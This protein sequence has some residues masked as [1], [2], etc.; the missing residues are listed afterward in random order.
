DVFPF[1]SRIADTCRRALVLDTN[2]SLSPREERAHDGFTYR[3][4]GLFEHEPSSSQEER[5]RAL[6]SSLDNPSA[7]IPTRPSLVS[8]LA[9]SGFTS[10]SECWIPAEPEKTPGRITL[11]A[12]KGTPQEPCISPPPPS[13]RVTVRERPPLG[14]RLPGTSLWRLGHLLPPGVRTR[15]QRRLGAEVRRH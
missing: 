1:V 12:L 14:A 3:G 7:W 4:E 10:V 15:L 8:L 6:W 2:V 13:D 11:L 9:R 5:L